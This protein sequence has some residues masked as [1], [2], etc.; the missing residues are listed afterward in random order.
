MF[1]NAIFAPSEMLS[2]MALTFPPQLLAMHRHGL[3]LLVLEMLLPRR[4]SVLS[5]DLP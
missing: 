3:Q 4:V 1:T 5:E 2:L